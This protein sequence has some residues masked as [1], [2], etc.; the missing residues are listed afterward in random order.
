[1]PVS[2]L[3]LITMAAAQAFDLATFTAMVQRVGP[4]AEVNPIV[5]SMLASLG[6]TPIAIVKAA[7]VILVGSVTVILIQHGWHSTHRWAARGV[8]TVAILA[9]LLG[10]LTNAMTIWA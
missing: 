9:G 7:L 4:H 3:S 8:V 2:T 5:Q 1:M 6:V 10:G